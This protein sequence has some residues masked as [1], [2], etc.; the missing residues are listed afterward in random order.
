MKILHFSGGNVEYLIEL[1][2]ALSE[3]QEV[4]EVMLILP[5]TKINEL[6]KKVINKKVILKSIEYIYFKSIRQNSKMMWS[7]LKEIIKFKPNVIH[8]QSN[9][10]PWFWTILPFISK[11]IKI[12]NTIHD[13]YIHVGDLLSMKFDHKKSE[14][15]LKKRANAYIVHGEI[16]KKQLL[17]NIN[18]KSSKVHTIPHGDYSIYK[19]YQ[20][21][22]LE[23][24]ANTVLFFGRIWKYKG[25][26]Y[27]MLAEPIVSKIIP[28]FKIIIAG[29]GE[30]LENYNDYISN[31]DNYILKNYRIPDEEVGELFQQSSI[32]ILPYIDA[33][34]TGVL[35]IAYAYNK[36]VIAT[37]VGALADVVID[38][39]TGFLIAPADVE[40]LAE[41][42]IYLLQNS[43]I[44]K[45]MGNNA[46][47]FADK[48]LNWDKIAEAT[49]EVYKYC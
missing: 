33:S 9:A 29:S 42:I 6:Q 2:S 24:R 5:N 43:D 8:L 47:K 26:K 35:P 38:G 1:T 10:H 16:L 11:K 3:L 44:R 13:P 7:L 36:P 45:E 17:K 22:Y 21:N 32:V 49:L 46:R 34:Q 20:I 14:N 40:A 23:E 39:E 15:S 25:L 30:D 31:K 28:D 4:S 19:K 27:L 41:K 37:N 12:I 18:I 48:N